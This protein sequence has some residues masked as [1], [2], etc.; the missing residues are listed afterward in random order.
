MPVTQKPVPHCDGVEQAP[1]WGTGVLVGVA[2]G[3]L[4]GVCVGV[5]VGVAVGVLV[6]VCVGVDVGVAVGVLVG[7]EVGV[8]V[9][10]LVGVLVGV[11]V[12]LHTGNSEHGP[13]NTTVMLDPQRFWHPA[14][15]SCV[16]HATVLLIES[17]HWQ[18]S[19]S[20]PLARSADVPT[21]AT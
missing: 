9:G 16:K 7:V 15:M 17:T 8:C 1:P 18:H 10:V 3:V 6:G 20:A 21:T 14:S 5:F 11:A 12:G 13:G 2:V 4:V 19:K